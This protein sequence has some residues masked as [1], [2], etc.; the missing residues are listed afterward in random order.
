MA[1]K[2]TY[3]PPFTKEQLEQDYRTG[4]T[5]AEIAKRYQTSQKVVFNAMKKWGIKAR[6]AAKREQRGA[7]NSYWK[8]QSVG[9]AAFHKRVEVLKG[10][11]QQCEVCGTTDAS[12][13]YDWA[14]LTGR[15]ED[16]EDYQR[17]CRSCHW[18]HDG[19]HTNLGSFSQKKEV[20]FNDNI[21]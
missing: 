15:Y 18:K 3:N 17:M 9:Y 11:P 16:P 6:V 12:K 13:T 20:G 21:H 2:Y 1:N 4:L 10:R 5:Q 14:N 7:N 19:K 8:G